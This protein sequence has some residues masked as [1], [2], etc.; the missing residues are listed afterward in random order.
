M[1]GASSRALAV[2][3]AALLLAGIGGAYAFIQATGTGVAL[4][5]TA[6]LSDVHLSGTTLSELLPGGRPSALAIKFTNP[7][8]FQ[9]SAQGGI[10]LTI[11]TSDPS[12]PQVCNAD[13]FALVSVPGPVQFAP[14][15]ATSTDIPA[16]TGGTIAWLDSGD[17]TACLAALSGSGGVPIT[18]T[19]LPA[20][21]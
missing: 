14:S 12:W 17:Q 21:G 2:G 19:V 10:L 1:I 16:H 13:D 8:D 18:F 5:S 20:R 4:V 11:D 15:V 9:V 7:N 6:S 3:T